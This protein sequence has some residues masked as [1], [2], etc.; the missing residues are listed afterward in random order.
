MDFTANAWIA[1]ST[2]PQHD[3]ETAHY[4]TEEDDDV[5]LVAAIG[6]Y[7]AGTLLSVFL[8]GLYGAVTAL[9]STNPTVASFTASAILS[10]GALHIDAVKIRTMTGSLTGNAV[11]ALGGSTSFPADAVIRPAVA[12]LTAD[13]MV[14]DLV[15]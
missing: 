3:R 11:V 6:P 10:G 14:I 2:F 4:G 9:T 13:A 7:P 1:S 12:S 5:V 8:A 15:C